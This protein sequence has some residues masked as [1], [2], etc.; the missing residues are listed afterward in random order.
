MATQSY[1]RRND[2]FRQFID[3]LVVAKEGSSLPLNDMYAAFKDW[4]KE[5]IPHGGPPNKQEVADYFNKIWGEPVKENGL[6]K[7]AGWMMRGDASIN[8]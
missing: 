1:Q 4:F 3:E 5:S 8:F 6:K 7:W 2:V